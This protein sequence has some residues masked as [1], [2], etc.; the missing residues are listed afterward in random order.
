[1]SRAIHPGTSKSRPSS[2]LTR[3]I[4]CSRCRSNCAAVIVPTYQAGRKVATAVAACGPH[5]L[6]LTMTKRAVLTK[7]M[8][9]IVPFGSRTPT[10]ARASWWANASRAM[11]NLLLSARRTDDCTVIS[12]TRALIASPKAVWLTIAWARLSARSVGTT[13]II[14]ATI[15]PKLPTR[16]PSTA[17]V[18]ASM[19]RTLSAVAA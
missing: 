9:S 6:D 18:P 13:A 15:V 12:L 1:M 14:P 7:R 16:A 10:A 17:A 8:G 11:S 3:S 4:S 2:A 19:P 5:F